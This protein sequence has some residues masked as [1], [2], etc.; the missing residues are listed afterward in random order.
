MH[1]R[2]RRTRLAIKCWN[3][4]SQ[5]TN[6]HH[7]GHAQP[8]NAKPTS[9][10]QPRT[11]Q[12][13]RVRNKA[14]VPHVPLHQTASPTPNHTRANKPSQTQNSTCLKGLPT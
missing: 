7:K 8:S 12:A 11:R 3:A 2:C 13:L 4:A 5:T 6:H 14:A 9:Y 1:A 10:G